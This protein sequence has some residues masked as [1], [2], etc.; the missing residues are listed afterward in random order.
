MKPETFV[1]CGAVAMM[2]SGLALGYSYISHPHHMTPEVISGQFWIVVHSL[3]A[4]SLV[5]GLLGTVA[6]Y[7]PTALTSRVSG[8]VG[9]VL[10]FVGMLLIFGLDYYEVLIAPYLAVHYPQVI[11][12]HGA[13]D[14]M[15]PVAL[16]F[17]LAGVLT[18]FGY[19]LL[20]HAWMRAEHISRR[21]GLSLIVTALAFGV[22]LSPVGGIMAA[23]VT[24]A[25]FGAALVAVGFVAWKAG[26]DWA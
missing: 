9:F 3:F 12:E 5:L 2:L 21:I 13:G 23:Q 1:R 18:V 10:L 20:G 17:P 19:A 4:I 24:A 26:P 6:L 7:A 25:A 16:F 15:G 11:V 8:L 22:G 14:A